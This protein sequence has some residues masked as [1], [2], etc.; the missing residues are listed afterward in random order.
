MWDVVVIGGGP[1]GMMAIMQIVFLINCEVRINYLIL[2]I[3]YNTLLD[4]YKHGG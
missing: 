3:N 4:S 1:A 2:P